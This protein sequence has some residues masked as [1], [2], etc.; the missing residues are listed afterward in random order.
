[1]FSISEY[2]RESA[3]TFL[4]F[5]GAGA[6][7]AGAGAGAGAAAFSAGCALLAAPPIGNPA[8]GS[9]GATGAAFIG[10]T[11]FISELTLGFE[12]TYASD[13]EVIMKTMAAPVVIFVKNGAGPAPPKTVCEAP[14]NA[15]PISAPFP[16]W[17]STIKIS[18][19]HTMTWMITNNRY[20]CFVPEKIKSLK[21]NHRV[22]CYLCG[23]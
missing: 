3:S 8:A 6:C 2:Q 10:L 1:M 23:G 21:A 15:A 4:Y 11:P 9:A 16:V 13:R 22:Y 17:S 12:D 14:P 5:F 7:A 18:A 19:M 20:I